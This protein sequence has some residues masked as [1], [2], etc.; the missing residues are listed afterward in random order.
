M[1]IKTVFLSSTGKDLA[2]YRQAVA[3]AINGL[4]GYKCVRMEDFGA[5]NWKADDFCR[6]KVAECD[7]FVGIV[8]HFYGSCPSRSEQSYTER[9]Y[10]A[11]VAA[12]KPCL[13]F[14][15]PED[16]PIP[17]NL[18]EPARKRR[19]QRAF[20]ER[21]SREFTCDTFTSPKDLAWRVGRAI[22]NWEQEQ[23]KANKRIDVEYESL[24]NAYIEPGSVFE[25]AD[26]DHFVG[27]EWLIAEVDAFLRDHDRGYF[28]LEAEAGLGKTTFL[29][30]LIKQR[31]YIHHFTE[32]TPGL[33]GMERGLNNLAAQLVLTYHLKAHKAEWGL[34]GFAT[35]PDFLHRLLKLAAEQRQE[36]EKVVV[37]VD[38]LDEAGMLPGQNVL[39]LPKVLPEG[40]YIIV[41]QRPVPVTVQA[42]TATTPRCIFQLAAGSAEN[43]NDMRRFLKGAATWPGI[44]RAL[45]ER[46]YTTEQFTATLLDKCRG[47]W[48]Y[49]H[50]MIHEI[51][52]RERSPLDLDALPDGMTQ[53]YARYWRCWRDTD[54][55][56]QTYLP[57][58]TTMAA[59]QEA[60]TVE[61]LVGWAS[62]TMCKE[63]LHSLLS[64][65]WRPFIAPVC[66]AGQT[67]YRF[68]HKTLQE[69]FAGQV[70]LGGLL[71]AEQA[72]VEI[73]RQ[74]TQD[75]RRRVI[76]SLR[77][78]MQ[79][80]S[81]PPQERRRAAALLTR[82]HWLDE[83]NCIPPDELTICLE[84]V[85]AYL[86]SGAERHYLLHHVNVALATD[87]VRQSD[88]LRARLLIHQAALLGYLKDFD[89]ASSSYE[90]AK[91]VVR[92]IFKSGKGEPEDN[93]LAARLYLGKANL[94]RQRAES[95]NAPENGERLQEL[96]QKAKRLYKAAACFAGA[97]GKDPVLRATIYKELSWNFAL[98]RDW[99]RAEESYQ[100]ALQLLEGVSDWQAYASYRAR[101]LE[102]A[103]YV[104]WEKGESL[105]VQNLV[106]QAVRE[107][108]TACKLT[109][110]E[111]AEL[112]RSSD[113]PR[114]LVIAHI[115]CGEYLL[116]LY[117]YKPLGNTK[118]R[119]LRAACSHWQRAID[120]AHSM[121]TYDLEQR[122]RKHLEQH[123]SS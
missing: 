97:Y 28:I 121:A 31:R 93:R 90:A 55:W 23:D 109:Q 4:D 86:N 98:L 73:L 19:R 2:E 12:Q 39:G 48:I 111:I 94:T 66:H 18:I 77:M 102:T 42:D 37:V 38:A 105:V 67:R 16:F 114:R 63:E 21:V 53:Y 26:L 30:W 69:F 112:K 24:R 104:H 120:L 78:A 58:L 56:Y 106:E 44:D 57:L 49:L 40:V 76:Q 92:K 22:H 13:M 99:Q 80:T 27:R 75:A 11:A 68:Y 70:D 35:R 64:E 10:N 103:G 65:Q 122:A 54:K 17:A 29:A 32:L 110:Q 85:A 1:S 108:R 107:Y 82:L 83:A 89:D 47:V 9:E 96:L 59:V 84:L 123:C 15:A 60:V 91:Q 62:V 115:N 36:G 3:D 72:F 50:F 43:Q 7:V 34:P 116:A 71:M 46:S 61:E 81:R 88:R 20:R 74:A 52:R 41:S 8:G 33:D 51:E 79:D 14:I 119:H 25:R 5:R 87:A 118:S 100:K 101:V 6:A 113:E 117:K 95:L 45:R